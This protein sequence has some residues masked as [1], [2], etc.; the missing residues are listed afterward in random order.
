MINFILQ[1]T[2]VVINTANNAERIISKIK[3]STGRVL[4]DAETL[5]ITG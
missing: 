3:E 2:L 4:L 5:I 1:A